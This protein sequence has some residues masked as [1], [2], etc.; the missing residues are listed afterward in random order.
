MSL[1]FENV[2]FWYRTAEPPLAYRCCFEVPAQQF[3]AVVGESG[4]GK[5][6]LLRLGC[7]LLQLEH[8]MA[9]ELGY[10]IEGTVSYRNQCVLRPSRSF[11]YVPQ[12]YASGLLPSLTARENILLAVK[13]HGISADELAFAEKLM[14]E[15]GIIDVAHLPLRHLSGGQ[16]QRVAICRALVTH[17]SVLFM[18]EPF[19]SLDSGLKP[20]MSK[21][22][23]RLRDELG[24]SLMFVTH[25]IENAAL[26][27]DLVLGVK[28]TYGLPR[29]RL[30]SARADTR[31]SVIRQVE[32]WIGYV[33][34]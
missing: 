6:T 18:D 9:P 5:T 30:W 8:R 11:G 10:R 14:T 29:H 27:G 21:L 23:L 26:L 20:E 7:G 24:L 28:R 4:G 3:L 33:H 15:S 32:D 19:A 16:K 31:C 25:D 2:S 34:G 13:E 12:N 1:L 17:P 22:L